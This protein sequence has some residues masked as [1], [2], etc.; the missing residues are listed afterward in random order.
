VRTRATY[1]VAARVPGLGVQRDRAAAP[2]AAAAW[3]ALLQ[4]SATYAWDGVQGLAL[5]SWVDVVAGVSA[6]AIGSGTTLGTLGGKAAAVF[7]GA[8]GFEIASLPGGLAAVPNGDY[9]I[10]AIA[11]GAT[12]FGTLMQLFN[13]S[14]GNP[15][16][17]LL[18]RSAGGTR[19]N[20]R[21]DAGTELSGG[22]LDAAA[23][24]AT[25]QLH[26]IRRVGTTFTARA[27][28]TTATATAT[29]GTTTVDRFR[30]GIG[31]S[32]SLPLTGTIAHV[33]IYA[34]GQLANAAA[35]RAEARAYY[36][37]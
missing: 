27:T 18:Y 31:R 29:I 16:A 2:N 30:I 37:V 8:G 1:G 12:S 4:S 13:A 17:N 24:Q 28:N 33:S 3:L 10:I 32:N 6:A 7:A 9:E 36:G 21:S 35:M 5:A 34:G 14:L 20:H 22:L 15:F 11:Q 25:P 26:S 23:T 19:I